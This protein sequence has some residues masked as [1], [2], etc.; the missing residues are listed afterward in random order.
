M[1][2][3]WDFQVGVGNAHQLALVGVF[4]SKLSSC[5]SSWRS[6]CLAVGRGV[7]G[8][9]SCG[10]GFV[11]IRL[12]DYARCSINPVVFDARACGISRATP[13]ASNSTGEPVVF[14]AHGPSQGGATAADS[15]VFRALWIAAELPQ[16]STRLNGLW[17]LT[18][19]VIASAFE[20][21]HHASPPVGF[22]AVS[23]L[24][25]CFVSLSERGYASACG[26][27]GGDRSCGI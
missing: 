26:F 10:H 8:K 19:M 24:S 21:E 1:E 15:V 3:I 2:A 12:W 6:T 5:D 25:A 7:P 23:Q 11:Q 16:P 20:A 22:D 27:Q 9:S 4:V 18:R 17:D 14:H 13:I